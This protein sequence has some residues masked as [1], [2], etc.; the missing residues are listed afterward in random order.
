MKPTQ[1][2]DR[3]GSVRS[4]AGVP[5]TTWAS[6]FCRETVSRGKRRTTEVCTRSASQPN[7]DSRW[8]PHSAQ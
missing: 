8:P 4:S 5:I 6:W 3:V 7:G 2:T 1:P